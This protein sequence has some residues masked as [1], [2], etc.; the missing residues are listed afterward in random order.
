MHFSATDYDVMVVGG[1]PAGSTAATILAQHGHRV[2]MF[3]KDTHPRFHIGESMLPFSEPVLQRLGVDWSQ[4]GIAKGGAEF[5][6][7][8]TDKRM[9]FQLSDQRQAYQIERAA[10]DAALFDNA[11]KHGV[12][13]YQNTTITSVDMTVTGVQALAGD[14]EY[15]ARYLIDATGRNAL[16]ARR[17]RSLKRI[18]NL[19][20]FALYTHFSHVNSPVSINFFKNGNII[21]PIVDIGWIWIIPLAGQKVS[22]GLV[23]SKRGLEGESTTALFQN[24]L[25][26]SAYLTQLLDGASQDWPIRSEANFSYINQ[27][28]YGMRYVCCGDAAGFLDPVFSSGVFLALTGGERV[29][30]R[31]HQGLIDNREAEADLHSVD[32]TD[33]DLGF[34]TMQVFIERFYHTDLI[35]NVFFEA[36]RDDRIQRDISA[37]LAGDMWSGKNLW[38]QGLLRG[39]YRR[40]SRVIDT[41]PVD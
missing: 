18:E 38:Q 16:M 23:V 1:G 15:Y 33:Y 8:N 12:K 7:E 24:Y 37:L 3:E 29:A 4:Y 6:D 25:Q 35:H 17:N 19:G 36:E 28:R 31:V 5:I 39:R 11:R 14:V 22:V 30:D 27:Q 32:D 13:T 41:K 9:Y 2:A 10:F 40:Q 26:Q 21:V 20:K 34:S